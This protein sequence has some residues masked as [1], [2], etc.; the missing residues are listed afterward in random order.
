[1]SH[2]WHGIALRLA[3]SLFCIIAGKQEEEPF[4]AEHLREGPHQAPS[5][6]ES[7]RLHPSFAATTCSLC[8][9][10][11]RQGGGPGGSS[12]QALARQAEAEAEAD[13]ARKRFGNAKSISSAQFNADEES[14]TMDYEKQVGTVGLERQHASFGMQ[15]VSQ[16]GGSFRSS[17]CPWPPHA[18][19]FCMRRRA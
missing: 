16:P 11:H 7:D 14:K 13:Q 12:A 15:A 6:Q 4:I 9:A 18:R 17:P 10:V 2:V 1:M 3:S 8:D 5:V 19:V